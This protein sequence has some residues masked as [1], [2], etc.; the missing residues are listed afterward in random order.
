[1]KPTEENANSTV[2]Y[3]IEHSHGACE[4]WVERSEDSGLTTYRPIRCVHVSGRR[5]VSLE[6]EMMAQA[7]L[8]EEWMVDH[9]EVFTEGRTC[10]E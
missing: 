4:L 2:C 9:F 1:M 3:L 5:N 7:I 6:S 10:L 8:L